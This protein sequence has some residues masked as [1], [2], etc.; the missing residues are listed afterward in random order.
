MVINILFGYN[1]IMLN[2]ILVFEYIKI[3]IN[4]NLFIIFYLIERNVG[5]YFDY[6]NDIYVL[7]LLLRKMIFE[8]KDIFNFLLMK[9]KR[10]FKLVV[11]LYKIF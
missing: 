4:N 9:F 8:R 6:I 3:I 2:D 7:V 5:F 1:F 11:S 10:I